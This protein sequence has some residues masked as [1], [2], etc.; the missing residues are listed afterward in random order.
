[1]RCINCSAPVKGTVCEYCG[2]RYDNGTFLMVDG[3][4]IPCYIASWEIYPIFRDVGV[5]MEGRLMRREVKT[6]RKFE[7]VEIADEVAK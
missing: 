2:T 6:I 5:D 3:L 7:L 1:M 4:K